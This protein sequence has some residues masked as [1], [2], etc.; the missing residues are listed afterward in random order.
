ML[1][2]ERPTDTLT[3]IE[4]ATNYGL[5]PET[6]RRWIREAKVPARKFGNMLFIHASDVEALI[7][8]KQERKNGK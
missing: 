3:V 1:N 5:N 6:V 8:A 7:E 2:Q 4:L